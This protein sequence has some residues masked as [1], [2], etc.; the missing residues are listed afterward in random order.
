MSWISVVGRDINKVLRVVVGVAT[1]TEGQKLIG[2]IPV[3]GPIAN[4]IF[5]AIADVEGLLPAGGNGALKKSM[6]TA[7]VQNKLS[8]GNPP[9]VASGVP[10]PLIDPAALSDKIDKI[11]AALNAL[12]IELKGLG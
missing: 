7:I 2:D 9:N 12:D 4:T 6:A 5:G 11:V 1:S 10:A 8:A 3:Y